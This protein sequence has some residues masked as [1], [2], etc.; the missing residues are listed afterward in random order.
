MS[1]KLRERQKERDRERSLFE[2]GLKRREAKQRK[3]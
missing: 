3:E 1:Q 2:L